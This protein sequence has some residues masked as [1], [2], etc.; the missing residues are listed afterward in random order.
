MRISDW[1]SDVCSSDLLVI[2]RGA[3]ILLRIGGVDAID[4]GRLQHK[5]RLDFDRAQGR[6]RVGREEWIAGAGRAHQHA[7]FFE[8]T[9]RLATDEVLADLDD[10]DRRWHARLHAG[11]SDRKDDRAQWRERGWSYGE[12]SVAADLFK[13]Q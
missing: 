1:S 9:H 6:C 12:I 8:M 3:G 11:A 13:K 10:A 5:V 7:A 2:A 4:L